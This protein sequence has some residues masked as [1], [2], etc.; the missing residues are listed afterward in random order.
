LRPVEEQAE[1][2]PDFLNA[3]K[4][5]KLLSTGRGRTVHLLKTGAKSKPEKA[6]RKRREI[7]WDDLKLDR[8]KRGIDLEGNAI[9]VQE[10]NDMDVQRVEK[11][12]REA[13]H[14]RNQQEQKQGSIGTDG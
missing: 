10:S 6:R 1:I 7:G 3:F 12:V 2:Y 13:M 14:E 4:E 9:H 5:S 11:K 8:G